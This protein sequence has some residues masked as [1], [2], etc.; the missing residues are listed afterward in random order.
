MSAQLL[1]LDPELR[2]VLEPAG[3]T[4]PTLLLPSLDLE[5]VS[6]ALGLAASVFDTFLFGFLFSLAKIDCLATSDILC[7]LGELDPGAA[8][9]EGLEDD[10]VGA[11]AGLVLAVVVVINNPAAV[12][13][14]TAPDP[15]EDDD[16]DD[17]DIVVL[18]R[19]IL[20]LDVVAGVVLATVAAVVGPEA[21]LENDDLTVLAKDEVGRGAGLG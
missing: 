13:L 1:L 11:E 10:L 18:A 9:L 12:F 16:L 5:R 2:E 7:C 3:L 17:D 15:D 6:G 4:R 20:G 19:V 21:T 14:D 8:A